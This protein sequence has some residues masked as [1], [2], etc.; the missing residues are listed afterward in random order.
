MNMRFISCAGYYGS[1]SS[2][3][4]DFVS[5]FNNVSTFGDEEFRFLHDPD[6]IADLEYNLVENF[7][8]HNSGQAIKRYQKLVKYY[9]GNLFSRKYGGIFGILWE[10]YSREYIDQLTDFTYHG[11]W[12]Y[13]LIDRGSVFL[14]RK[15]IMNKLFHL[16]I[17]R[18]DP[19]RTLN[20]M[21]NEITYCAHPAEGKFIQLTKEYIE[22][23][24]DSVRG[25][26]EIIMAD[27]IVPSSNTER[28]LRYFDD[29]HVVIV[30]RDPRDIF[31][32]EKKHWKDG[33]IPR[34]A[35]TFCKWFLY[36][37]ENGKHRIIQ[38]DRIHYLQF[39]DMIYH[40]DE[41]AKKLMNW[42]GLNPEWHTSKQHFFC[43]DQSI[44]NTRLWEKEKCNLS[45]VR[46]IEEHLKNYLYDP[47]ERP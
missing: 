26:K 32:L 11:W 7:N 20:T 47:E 41:T 29:I 39:E 25:D 1:G 12:Q 13:D 46:Y 18:N 34:D 43:P 5:E 17:W 44:R 42:L 24:F 27:Q 19:E 23:L 40:Y 36:T 9:N 4:T 15:R 45:E 21:K 33:I 14:F 31:L 30:D 2:A 10:K 35:E 38:N 28:Y 22:K 37:R 3:V 16:T 6:G 8:R